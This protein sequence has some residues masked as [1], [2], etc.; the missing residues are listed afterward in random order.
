MRKPLLALPATLALLAGLSQPAMAFDPAAMTDSEKTAFGIAIRDYLLSHPEVVMEAVQA[1]RDKEYAAQSDRDTQMIASL[2]DQL[3]D[4]GYSWVGGNPEGDV[5]IV[6]FMD[7]RCGYCRQA[8]SEVEELVASDGNI[9]L[10]VKEYP[11]LTEGSTLSSQFAIAAKLI[12]GDD[13][14]KTLHDALIT[15]RADATPETLVDLANT[16]GFDGASIATRAQSF[17]VSDMIGRNHDLA[18]QLQIS[19]TPTFILNGTM[20]RGYE[21]LDSMRA[22][23]AALRAEG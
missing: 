18:R 2:E 12:Y 6:E 20:Q 7:Y 15:M 5:T 10:I 8:F 22:R 21:P 23:V 4:D 13:A 19:G 9:R 1:L 3:F 14:Y 16:L 17:E 11:I